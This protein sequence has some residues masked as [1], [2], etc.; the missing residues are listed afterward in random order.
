MDKK[1]KADEKR[2]AK[3]VRKTTEPS[4]LGEPAAQTIDPQT[5]DLL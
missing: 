5:G 4:L 1:H 3:K 2:V